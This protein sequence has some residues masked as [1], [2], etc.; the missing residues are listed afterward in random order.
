MSFSHEQRVSM[1]EHYF[2]SRSHP[3]PAVPNDSATTTLISRF[4]ERES[5]AEKKTLSGPAILAEAK[6][7]D[8]GRMLPFAPSINPEKKTTSASR[9]FNSPSSYWSIPHLTLL[10]SLLYRV[11]YWPF[12]NQWRSRA[13]NDPTK[14]PLSDD[15]TLIARA[16]VP[17]I[18]ASL[19]GAQEQETGCPRYLSVPAP[20]ASIYRLAF[21]TFCI[22]YRQLPSFPSG[23]PL[24]Q[25][26]D[27]NGVAGY[28]NVGAA[29]SNQ[30]L[31]N[32][33]PAGRPANRGS[34]LSK[35]EL[36]TPVSEITFTEG[37]L[38]ELLSTGESSALNW[39][40]VTY[41]R[42]P[43]EDPELSVPML[44]KRGSVPR[45]HA[46]HLPNEPIP[47]RFS[48]RL[49]SPLPRSPYS[50][51]SPPPPPHSVFRVALFLGPTEKKEKN[52][53]SFCQGRWIGGC[54]LCVCVCV[55]GG[56]WLFGKGGM[57]EI[58]I[59]KQGGR[60]SSNLIP[61]IR[62][63]R[64][65]SGPRW[66]REYVDI[67]KV[68][69]GYP[70][71]VRPGITLLENWI[72]KPHPP[73]LESVFTRTHWAA[74]RSRYDLL[75]G[76]G[77]LEGRF[78][79]TSAD[80]SG[81]FVKLHQQRLPPVR[82]GNRGGSVPLCIE[83]WIMGLARTS[84][85]LNWWSSISRDRIFVAEHHSP[86]IRKLPR[87]PFLVECHTYLAMLKTTPVVC[88]HTSHDGTIPSAGGP[89]GV[90]P[91]LL[92]GCV[93]PPVPTLSPMRA[94]GVS[95]AVQVARNAPKRLTFL[96]EAE[97]AASLSSSWEKG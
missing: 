35:P 96:S 33:P 92:N 62:D 58:R 42:R 83:T 15:W 18:A 51:P 71:R 37:H 49:S 21:D 70:C 41:S 63:G 85:R 76:I 91:R 24:R 79:E 82:C 5:A 20:T 69:Q 23:S 95:R 73:K 43:L 81:N 17:R 31:V 1:L 54:S 38:I 19:S 87:C 45:V 72:V 89:A 78:G 13:D 25:H 59:K 53:T 68:G 57:G 8:V 88:L 28:Q 77:H 86:A 61:N 74:N 50:P 90:D 39:E 34:L 67:T 4:R 40:C 7:A 55:R 3:H 94:S 48:S 11:H 6:L 14:C 84:P 75:I 2:I 16:V 44:H 46:G 26:L 65:V 66:P 12:I 36:A 22:G 64:H 30:R 27:R 60:L 93:Y 9:D 97:D 29:F 32:N 80:S 10:C 47:C 56:G 52:S